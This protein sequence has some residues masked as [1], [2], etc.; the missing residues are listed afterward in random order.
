[1]PRAPRAAVGGMVY[2]VLNRANARLRL[3]KSEADYERFVSVLAASHERVRMRTI[4]YCIMPNHP[5][6]P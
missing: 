2:H 1:M 5:P 6:S 4:G 3:F